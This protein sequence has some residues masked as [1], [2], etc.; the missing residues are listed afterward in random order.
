M[1]FYCYETATEFIYCVEGAEGKVYENLR[2]DRYWTKID[3]KFVK[4][5][6][7][8]TGWDDAWYLDQNYK[9][10]VINNFARLGQSWIEGVFD[11]EKVL[12]RIAKIFAE[13]GIR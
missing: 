8:D 7:M 10:A 4:I 2:S 5:Y 3:D 1:K 11:W 13:N 12:L 9:Q 6:P